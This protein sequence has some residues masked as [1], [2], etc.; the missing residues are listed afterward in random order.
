MLKL[1]YSIRAI[2]LNIRAI[3]QKRCAMTAKRYSIVFLAIGLL[4]LRPGNPWAAA[5]LNAIR[6]YDLL[7]FEELEADDWIQK[8]TGNQLVEYECN[9]IDGCVVVVLGVG[10]GGGRV[11]Y[12]RYQCVDGAKLLLLPSGVALIPDDCDGAVD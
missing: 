12:I 5:E 7:K 3:N 1:S 2:N 6:N 4:M 11:L 10:V 8:V 9:D